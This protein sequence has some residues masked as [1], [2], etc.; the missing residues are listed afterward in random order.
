MISLSLCVE[1]PEHADQSGDASGLE[2]GEQALSLVRQVVEDAGCGPCCL[3]VARVLHRP[4]NRCHHLR[5]LHQRTPRRLLARKLVDNL[6]G[7]ADHHLM[8]HE[9]VED[10]QVDVE[11][12]NIHTYK[13][14]YPKT[15]TSK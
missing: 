8:R 7:L 14:I 1:V 2:D 4:H 11:I 9:K 10:S 12:I 5:G 3:H 6:C 15:K 13:Y